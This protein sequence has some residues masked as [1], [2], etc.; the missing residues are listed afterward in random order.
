MKARKNI[1]DDTSKAEL[2]YALQSGFDSPS[3]AEIFYALQSRWR[4]RLRVCPSLR[5]PK[6]I[7]VDPDNL[8]PEQ[9]TM[10]N[11]SAVD[12]TFCD[13]EGRLLFSMDIDE[14]G[15]GFSRGVVYKEG[16]EPLAPDKKKE[17]EFKLKVANTA[18]YPLI[19]VSDEEMTPVDIDH[20]SF[21]VVDGMVGRFVTIAETK[22][23][24]DDN[25]EASETEIEE[26][27]DEVASEVNPIVKQINEY[28][29]LCFA[30][31]GYGSSIQYL[32]DPPRPAE[33][34]RHSDNFRHGTE[35]ELYDGALRVGCR[36]VIKAPELPNLAIEETMWL[37][38]FGSSI[39]RH[40]S[41][42]H[43][44]SARTVARDIAQYKALKQAFM[45]VAQSV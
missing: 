33:T 38:N 42:H 30:D 35:S 5:L 34:E 17:I 23:L 36:V 41:W 14:V 12:L 27:E 8:S 6:I 9:R 10:L 7:E 24:L 18:N 2:F 28:C 32:Y 29:E 25:S 22:K 31:S 15:G 39:G 19:V 4:H 1:F 21:T 11:K 3:K 26:I 45:M 20:D 44:I 37:R 40:G 43:E 16:R 13:L